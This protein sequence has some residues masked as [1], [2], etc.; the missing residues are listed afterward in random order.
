MCSSETFLSG[1][2]N[3]IAQHLMITSTCA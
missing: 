3:N 2:Y 1:L